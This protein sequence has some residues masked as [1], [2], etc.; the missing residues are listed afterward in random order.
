MIQQELLENPLQKFNPTDQRTIDL[1]DGYQRRISDYTY[2]EVFIHKSDFN[3]TAISRQDILRENVHRLSEQIYYN[4]TYSRVGG[5]YSGIDE[6]K[7]GSF[8]VTKAYHD[9]VKNSAWQH[10]SGI[11]NYVYYK[12]DGDNIL[13]LPQKRKPIIIDEYYDIY[14]EEVS[15]SLLDLYSKGKPVVLAYSGSIDSMAMLAIIIKLGLLDKTKLVYCHNT[16]CRFP[17]IDLSAEEKLGIKIDHVEFDYEKLLTY[18]NQPNPV[19]HREF[20]DCWFLE[21]F[22]D[23]YIIGGWNG[24]RLNLHHAL[25]FVKSGKHFRVDPA[26]LYGG[27][28]GVIDGFTNALAGDSSVINEEYDPLR[29]ADGMTVEARVDAERFIRVLCMSDRLLEAYKNIDYKLTPEN[30]EYYADSSFGKR[31]IMENAGSDLLNII[32]TRTRTSDWSVSPAFRI[33]LTDVDEDF[34]QIKF[35]KLHNVRGVKWLKQQINDA[36]TASDIKYITLASIKYTN[37]LTN[38]DLR[39][40]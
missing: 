31:V 25:Q 38:P 5:L 37:W 16:A 34:L 12:W 33:P 23:S 8:T 32:N 22:P 26:T 24:N 35:N 3:I 15:K 7:H 9:P 21:L 20:T 28:Q 36:R 6:S 19:K 27:K 17:L 2:D 39:K 14:V 4:P 18:I 10:W 11:N 1:L 13:E 40:F 30:P 29:Q